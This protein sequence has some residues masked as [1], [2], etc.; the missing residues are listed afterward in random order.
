MAILIQACVDLGIGLETRAA[1]LGEKFSLK[2]SQEAVVGDEGLRLKFKSVDEDSRCPINLFCFWAGNARIT[3]E[4]PDTNLVLN[5]TLEPKMAT[6]S[7]YAIKLTALDP[8]P[9]SD[10]P[11]KPKDY[12]AI[13][14]VSKI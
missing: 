8:Y 13:L 7:K 12:T 11:I 14:V 1:R 9:V 4:L 10:R 5:T 3:I 2:L 6:Y